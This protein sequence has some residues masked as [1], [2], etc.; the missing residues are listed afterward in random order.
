MTKDAAIF[1][2][3]ITYVKNFTTAVDV[4]A[5]RGEWTAA[6]AQHFSTVY[7]FEPNSLLFS[8]LANWSMGSF[9]DMRLHGCA[10]LD[11]NGNGNLC[12]DPE[13]PDKDRARF[14]LPDKNGG[15]E[16][17]T[18]ESF[19]IKECG[20]L[21]VDV[22]GGELRALFGA[23][24]I[25][26]HQKPVIVVEYKPKN[27][28]RFGWSLANLNAYMWELGYGRAFEKK[29]NLVFVHPMSK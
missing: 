2:R 28:A 11:I 12:C 22:E 10:I 25:L 20:L 21:K 5:Y 19:R 14:A 26:R 7:S 6:M 9:C 23:R 13:C 18:L 15:V 16:V 3:V 8:R 17:R 4:G 1:D 29:P 24:R 27:A